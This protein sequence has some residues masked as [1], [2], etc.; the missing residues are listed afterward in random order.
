[1][2]TYVDS[3]R[4]RHP[5]RRVDKWSEFLN[6]V[7]CDST[8]RRPLAHMQINPYESPRI[9]SDAKADQPPADS[10]PEGRHSI[11]AVQ[12][13]RE[14]LGLAYRDPDLSPEGQTDAVGV[15]RVLLELA[16]DRY[17]ARGKQVLIDWNITR[18]E[19]VGLIVYRLIDAE[20]ASR[21]PGDAREDFNGLFDLT[22]PPE[23]WKLTWR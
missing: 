11:A 6:T 20:L 12:F 15:C 23:T 19:D 2:E 16:V 14:S 7:F 4:G 5:P 22:M 1:M 8:N 18:S 13:I 10:P 9:L 3:D 21:S 17:G